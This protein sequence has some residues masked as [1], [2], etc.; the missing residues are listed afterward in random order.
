MNSFL[1]SAQA[2]ICLVPGSNQLPG[3]P[4]GRGVVR[5]CS[6]LQTANGKMEETGCANPA[7][8]A[9]ECDTGDLLGRERLM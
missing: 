9:A 6:Y 7:V 2:S 4:V 3:G 1:G 5:H 8:A